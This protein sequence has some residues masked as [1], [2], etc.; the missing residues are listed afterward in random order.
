MRF[1]LM[2]FYL[3]QQPQ[4]SPPPPH[5]RQHAATVERCRRRAPVYCSW[6]HQVLHKPTR[7]FVT[8]SL[9][10]MWSCAAAAQSICS[11]KISVFNSRASVLDVLITILSIWKNK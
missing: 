1:N 7:Y 2:G 4:G 6:A 10:H 8:G 9:D 3:Q 11:G 5:Y